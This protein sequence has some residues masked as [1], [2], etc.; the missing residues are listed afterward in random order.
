MPCA[1]PP[2]PRTTKAT[3][4]SGSSLS[5]AVTSLAAAPTAALVAERAFRSDGK[6]RPCCTNKRPPVP[7]GAFF[8]SYSS[9]RASLRVGGG[10]R[11]GRLLA[12]EE[13]R[14]EDEE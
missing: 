8:I 4:R 2:R 1:R 11:P 12:C 3:V 13:V 9:G 5:P 10:R 14:A 6:Q 7:P